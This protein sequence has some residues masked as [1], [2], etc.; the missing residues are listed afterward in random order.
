VLEVAKSCGITVEHVA[1]E[2]FPEEKKSIIEHF[3][4]TCMIGDGANDSL[5][6]QAADVGI[7]VKGSVDLSLQS[8]DIYFTRGGLM[9]FLDLLKLAKRTRAVLSRN[10]S[11]SLIYNVLGGAFALLGFINPMMAAILMPISS[12]LIILSSLWGFR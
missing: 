10:L 4:N 11:I 3:P 12:A 6:L 9:P 2:L 1:Y 7:A 5:S 8:A